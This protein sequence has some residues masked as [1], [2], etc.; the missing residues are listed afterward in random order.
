MDRTPSGNSSRLH[1]FF[2]AEI[3]GRPATLA[4]VQ[5]TPG[6]RDCVEEDA[7]CFT[8][9]IPAEMSSVLRRSGSIDIGIRTE[10]GL[11]QISAEREA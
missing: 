8:G 11:L 9:R 7:G 3:D 5:A 6:F 4:E 10:A 1:F 2:C